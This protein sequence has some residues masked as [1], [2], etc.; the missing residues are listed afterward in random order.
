MIEDNEPL[1][2]VKAIAGKTS[3][4][5]ACISQVIER[6]VRTIMP[7]KCISETRDSPGIDHDLEQIQELV[8]IPPGIGMIVVNA[9]VDIFWHKRS[10]QRMQALY[11][12]GDEE[13][14][15]GRMVNIEQ[16]TLVSWSS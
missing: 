4:A 11:S 12:A 1:K 16:S 15:Y 9:A 7:Y 5:F 6:Q 14:L 13:M 10:P 3:Y 8:F 2:I